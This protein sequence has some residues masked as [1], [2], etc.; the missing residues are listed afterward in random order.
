MK[1]EWVKNKQYTS[2]RTPK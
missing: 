1:S 2:C